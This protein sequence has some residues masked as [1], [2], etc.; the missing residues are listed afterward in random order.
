ME[1]TG[2][3]EVNAVQ[4][5]LDSLKRGEFIIVADD[6]ES[7]LA[8]A[9]Q[10]VTDARVTFM[11]RNS[12]GIVSACLDQERLEGFGLHPA[13]SSSSTCQ[14]GANLY[15]STDYIQSG[16]AG[17]SAKGRAATLRGLC[18]T[19][20]GPIMFSK[21]GSTIPMRASRGGVLECPRHAEAVYDLCRLSDLTP[22]GA[23]T[24]LMTQDGNLS[25]IEDARQF[26]EVHKIPVLLIEQLCQHRR[27]CISS[28]G[29]AAP[30]LET[31]SKLWIEDVEAECMIR[32]YSV[33]D[34]KVE[35]VAICKGDVSGAEGVPVRVHSEC[36]TGDILG[37]KR[38]DC[39]QQLHK[40]LRIMNAETCGVLLYIR[41]HEGRGIGLSNKIRAYKLQDEGLDTVEANLKLGLP[42]DQR[43]YDDS[44]AVI[45][46]LGVKSVRLYTNNPDKMQALEPITK[47]VIALAS[48][49]CERNMFYLNTKLRKLK[50]RTVL[51]TFK[52]PPM[53][54]E[55]SKVRIGVV[56]AMWNK[57][58]VDELLREAEMELDRKGVQH[59]KMAVPGANELISGARALLKRR[60]FDSII[61]LGLLIR[62]S[63]DL[64]E[65]TC[66][67]VMTGLTELNASQDTPVITGVL[68][69]RDED[70][71]HERT[72]GKDNPAK[73]WADTAL[74]MALISK[75]EHVDG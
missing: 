35:V 7:H 1:S 16:I 57:Y 48:V 38:C 10:H 32:V 22:V 56:Y 37:S 46:L 42:V 2:Q 53:N 67:A 3:D 71:A 15:V 72:H 66:G 43:T 51:E 63:T 62:G 17:G 75:G 55:A 60:C 4:S 45:R 61:V 9:A 8:M 73:A 70:Q 12:T 34:P 69:C 41:G 49:P 33:A 23:L 52:L 59:S 58:F 36:F 21:P 5:C 11:I 18:D 27:R 20:N 29:V 6:Q 54:A 24:Q 19:S 64:Y 26:A 31:E 13:T 47:E 50:H 25:G 44:L 68:M 39:G 14:S 65:A 28:T 74:H 30:T 40:F